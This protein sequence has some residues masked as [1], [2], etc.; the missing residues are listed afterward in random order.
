MKARWLVLATLAALVAMLTV[1]G[2][3]WAQT[4]SGGLVAPDESTYLTQ[5]ALAAECA[6]SSDICAPDGFV[7]LVFTEG[8]PSAPCTYNSTTDWGDGTVEQFPDIQDGDV[9]SHQYATPGVYTVRD[10]GTASSSD[11][12]VTCTY[13]ATT[14]TV[15]VPE[16]D[17][18]GDG[19][20]DNADNCPLISNPSQADSDEDGSG[21]ACDSYTSRDTDKDGTPDAAHNCM[22][23]SNP[24]QRDRDQDGIGNACDNKV[25]VGG[26]TTF[27]SQRN[28]N[29]FLRTVPG[30]PIIVATVVQ[31]TFLDGK[32]SRADL[33]VVQ[34]NETMNDSTAAEGPRSESKMRTAPS[35]I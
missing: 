2:V 30:E 20:P 32:A 28:R 14:F 29:L 22:A 12:E 19:H 11:P 8:D 16:A 9:S 4:V 13:T 34:F 10:T 27:N 5:Q 26:D 33:I 21:D 6:P 25:G 35:R 1:T 7:E 3:A 24:G 17:T 18:D 15:E 31:D 23:D